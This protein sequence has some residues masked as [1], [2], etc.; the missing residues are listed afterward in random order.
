MLNRHFEHEFFWPIQLPGDIRAD[1]V[2]RALYT[3]ARPEVL[4]WGSPAHWVLT[5]WCVNPR[6]PK[7]MPFD[8]GPRSQLSLK[9][10]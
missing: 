5:A 7:P 4:I 9:F 3:F 8:P 2:A 10:V 1:E 6:A